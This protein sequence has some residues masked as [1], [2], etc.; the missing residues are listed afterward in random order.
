MES[1]L[2]HTVAHR[3]QEEGSRITRKVAECP[4]VLKV[5]GPKRLQL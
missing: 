5:S 4:V 2:E 1:V 3:V